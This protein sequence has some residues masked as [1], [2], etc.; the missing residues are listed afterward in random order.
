MVQPGAAE[1]AHYGYQIDLPGA[2]V[3]QVERELDGSIE[4]ISEVTVNYAESEWKLCWI[5]SVKYAAEIHIFSERFHK[6]CC[7]PQSML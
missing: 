1:V 6:I 3:Q 2:Q 4:V 7:A 5:L